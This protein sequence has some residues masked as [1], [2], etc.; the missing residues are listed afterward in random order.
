ME[1]LAAYPGMLKGKFLYPNRD[2][3]LTYYCIQEPALACQSFSGATCPSILGALSALE[4]MQEKW[5]T[6]A[7]VE[8]YT[9]VVAGLEKGLGNLA[10]WYPSIKLEYFKTN[11]DADYLKRGMGILYDVVRSTNSVNDFLLKIIFK[12]DHYARKFG[13]DGNAVVTAP[14]NG[15][16]QPNNDKNY[17]TAWMRRAVHC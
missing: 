3:A 17:S 9:P 13:N 2:A 11:W 15:Q 14:D 10:K 7:K 5:E 4:F 1:P 12:F 6:M 16:L 8:K